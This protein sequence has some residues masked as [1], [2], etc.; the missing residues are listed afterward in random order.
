MD[1]ELIEFVERVTKDFIHSDV[2]PLFRDLISQCRIGTS[3]N[4][5][6]KL[7][8][9]C[10][11]SERENSDAMLG[12]ISTQEG[13]ALEKPLELEP[14]GEN[15]IESNNV[16]DNLAEGENQ[17]L[18]SEKPSNVINIFVKIFYNVQILLQNLSFRNHVALIY[19]ESCLE[20]LRQY[21]IGNLVLKKRIKK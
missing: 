15:I 2:I 6:R 8:A 21:F 10:N 4:I 13:S 9:W 11:D 1:S 3:E 18:I 17:V 12:D 19:H 7:E 14:S 5:I 20:I 16:G